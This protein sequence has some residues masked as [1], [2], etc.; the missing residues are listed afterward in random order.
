LTTKEDKAKQCKTETEKVTAD[1]K[2][3]A[4]DKTAATAE[5]TTVT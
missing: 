4:K 5:I 1:K 2:A 3:L